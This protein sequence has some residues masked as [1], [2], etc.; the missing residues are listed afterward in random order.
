MKNSIYGIIAI[1]LIG[2]LVHQFTPWWSIVIVAAIVGAIFHEHAGRSFLYGFISVFLLWGIASFQI[3]AGN[4][5]ILST[6]MAEI[7]GANM[8][9]VTGL[10]GG[11]LGLTTPNFWWFL[12]PTLGWG[13]GIVMHY[14]SVFGISSPSGEDWEEKEM[15]KE[16]RKIKRQHFVEPDDENI[17]LPD[18][19]LELKEFKKLRDEW[20]DRDFV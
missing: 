15:E 7:F 17:T 18:D 10:L 9:L 16:M 3:D 4:E 14:I 11:L 1:I 20:D 8:I 13:I 5:S 2:L 6:R 12:F 19:E